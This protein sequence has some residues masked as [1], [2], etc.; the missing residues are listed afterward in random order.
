MYLVRPAESGDLAALI[1]LGTLSGT[2]AG[3]AHRMP[4][5]EACLA[6]AIADSLDAFAASVAAPAGETYLFVLVRQ[7]DGGIDGCATL[8]AMAGAGTPCFAFRRHML[9][10]VSSDLGMAHEMRAM[11]LSSDLSGYSHLAGRFLR[12]GAGPEAAALLARAP[13]LYAASAPQRF[14]SHF[15]ASFPAA[16][17]AAFWDALG[18]H[19]FDCSLEQAETLLDGARQHPAVVEMMPHYPVYLDLLPPD[20]QA[21]VGQADAASAPFV[22]A[23]MAHGFEGG[24]YAGLFDGGAILHASS[25]AFAKAVAP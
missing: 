14:A 22:R 2:S 6:R 9:R 13:L 12:P 23:L 3:R 18:R 8:Q 7:D 24:Q 17:G 10:Q 20:A 21:V 19:F 15:F 1:A 5:G 4:V 11:T 16:G 25:A